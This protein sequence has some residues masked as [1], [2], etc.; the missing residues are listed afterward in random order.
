MGRWRRF[1]SGLARGLLLVALVVLL[2]VVA[3]LVLLQTSWSREQLRALI[4]TQ[5][6]HYLTATLSIG[7][8]SGS[9]VRGIELDD[10]RLVRGDTTLVAIDRV[11]VA[12]SIRELVS[13]GTVIRSLTLDRPRIVAA[14]EPDGRWNLGALVRRDT[15]R[16]QRTGPGRRIVISSIDINEGSVSLLDP[17]AF[18]AAH[19]P[20]RFE[21]LNTHFSFAYQ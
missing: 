4:V 18:G 10:V 9:L 15:Q 16:N 21:H 2:L 6:N 7:R 11:T 12:Y 5:A 20:S 19:V 1:G 13:N 17:L 14:R 3:G 8:L